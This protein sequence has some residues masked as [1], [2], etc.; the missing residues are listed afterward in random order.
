ME[1]ASIVQSRGAFNLMVHDSTY[2]SLRA[3][4]GADQ[5][6]SWTQKNGSP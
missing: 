3:L 1:N 4:L 6:V 5:L 2:S